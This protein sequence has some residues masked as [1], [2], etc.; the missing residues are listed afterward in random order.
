M[1]ILPRKLR[2]AS[3][4]QMP[5]KRRVPSKLRVVSKLSVAEMI[6]KSRGAQPQWNSW[7]SC[8][9]LPALTALQAVCPQLTCAGPLV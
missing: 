4:L 1:L 3:K 8:A 5:G 9:I 6:C 2:V 7:C